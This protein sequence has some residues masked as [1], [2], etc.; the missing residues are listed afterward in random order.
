MLLIQILTVLIALALYLGFAAV[1]GTLFRARGNRW[2]AAAY[3]LIFLA[4][5]SLSL[6]FGSPWRELAWLAALGVMFLYFH[7]PQHLPDWLFGMRF[8]FGYFGTL[9]LGVLAWALLSDPVSTGLALGLPAAG[10]ALLGWLRA[11]A[12]HGWGRGLV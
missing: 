7:R 6:P 2:L 10:A 12:F 11:V 4:P 1:G 3:V 8:V 9:M 5:A